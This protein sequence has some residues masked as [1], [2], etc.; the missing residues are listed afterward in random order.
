MMR[1]KWILVNAPPALYGDSGNFINAAWKYQTQRAVLRRHAQEGDCIN[2]IWCDEAQQF[3][4]SHDAH[5][6]AQCRSH[7][8][9]MVFL[10][11][12]LH[13]Y[14]SALKGMNG[15]HQADALLS[16]FH[17]KIFHALGDVQTAEWASNLVGKSLQTFVGG[18]MPPEEDVFGAMMG[19]TRFTGSFSEHFE[20]ILQPNVF[21]G[22]MR[23][24]GP[25]NG[26]VCDAIIIRSGEK[27]SNGES[28]LQ[29]A[30]SQQ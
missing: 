7:L 23:T 27:F 21:L 18:S 16:N 26:Y 10:T 30:F 25:S 4:N 2:V 19:F 9:C 11:Q 20:N 5:Y 13:S 29:V 28:F 6:L 1:G 14:Y 17:T 22:G 12:S 24:G 3:V 15:R 8:G